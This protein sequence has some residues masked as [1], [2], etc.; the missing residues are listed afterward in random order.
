MQPTSVLVLCQLSQWAERLVPA[1]ERAGCRPI[2]VK[3][4][5]EAGRTDSIDRGAFS[6]Y[7]LV[8]VQP[9]IL[10]LNDEA[11]RDWARRFPA[12]ALYEVRFSAD[13]AMSFARPGLVHPGGLISLEQVLAGVRARGQELDGDSAAM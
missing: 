5:F 12:Q 6:R 11:F 10:A 7:D 9:T 8:L 3:P 13:G 4:V 1:L 2:V